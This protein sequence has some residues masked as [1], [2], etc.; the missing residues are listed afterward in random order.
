MEPE[1]GETRR[2]AL[3]DAP[4]APRRSAD[5]EAPERA[6]LERERAFA[7][8]TRPASGVSDDGI[9][10]ALSPTALPAADG[11][12]RTPL[13]LP[14]R[15]AAGVLGVGFAVASLLLCLAGLGA[16]TGAGS[17]LDELPLVLMS[18]PGVYLSRMFLRAAWSR[19]RPPDHPALPESAS[20][21]P[22]GLPGPDRS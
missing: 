22:P 7:L 20:R 17:F 10:D 14:A 5:A 8:A 21:R 6:R 19:R 11:E 2:R 4:D 12:T 18:V 16:L 13:R 3:D 15:I 9:L 1:P